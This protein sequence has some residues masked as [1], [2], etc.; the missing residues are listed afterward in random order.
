MRTM[1]YCQASEIPSAIYESRWL[2]NGRSYKTEMLITMMRMSRSLHL[3]AGSFCPLTLDTYIGV[4][5]RRIYI[6]NN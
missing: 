5:M 6:L 3:T 1:I 2:E 4:C